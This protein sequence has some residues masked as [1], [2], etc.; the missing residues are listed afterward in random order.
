MTALA[1]SRAARAAALPVLAAALLSC[2][3]QAPKA[4]PA[5]AS[6]DTG[7]TATTGAPE[8]TSGDACALLTKAEV[9][10]AVGAAAAAS[11]PNNP[12]SPTSCTW[13]Q[14]D[15]RYLVGTEIVSG[16]RAAY[17]AERS[18]QDGAKGVPGLGDDAYEVDESE[19]TKVA[20]AAG[21]KVVEVNAPTAAGARELAR[22][23]LGR[24]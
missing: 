2:G 4:P 21:D 13:Y 23:A 9:E 19:S 24:L 17:D 15:G 16:G 11:R 14:E 10:Q 18:T 1:R 22:Q 12:D 3:G 8:S 6:T 5:P 7:P 20:A